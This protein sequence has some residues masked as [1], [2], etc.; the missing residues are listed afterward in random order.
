VC[1]SGGGIKKERRKGT[2]PSFSE[3]KQT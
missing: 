1:G 2:T 3:Y